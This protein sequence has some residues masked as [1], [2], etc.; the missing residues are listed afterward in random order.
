MSGRTA[1]DFDVAVV[2]GGPAGM[3]AAGQAAEA[4]S[5][6]VLLE[7]NP[8]PGKKLGITGKGRCNITND[9]GADEFLAHVVTGGRFLRSALSRFSP[10]DTMDFFQ[11]LGLPL[12]TERG[13][14]VFPQSDRAGD[15]TAA[16]RRWLDRCG[17]AV[18][19][20]RVLEIN[21]RDGAVLGLTCSDGGLTCT[22]AVVA[23]GG[24][25]YP[26]TGCTGDGYA[27][28]EACGHTVQ[29]P[30]PSLVPVEA[31]GCAALQGLGLK[32]VTLSVYSGDKRIFHEMGELLFT[33][34]GVSGPLVLS[35]S[36]VMRDCLIERCR[37]EIDL[38]P[39]LHPEQLN[40]RL[41]RDLS[42]HSNKAVGNVLAL[43]LH[44]R[45]VPAMLEAC[46]IDPALPA[47]TLTKKQRQTLL[48]GIKRYVVAPTGLRPIDEAVVTAGGVSLAEIDP[49]TMASK[50][51]AGL[52][53]AGEVMDL[54][55]QTGGYNLQ[56]AWTTGYAAGRAAGRK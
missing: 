47:H 26:G 39:G 10:G 37:L 8:F 2:G 9:C 13:R 49:K 15:V 27:M 18:R 34:F 3:M 24:L 20:T 29:T 7:R 16:L 41:L 11:S 54:D 53:F 31:P 6:V 46:G 23:T 33:H 22:R 35:A 1:V 51:C 12:K 5:R 48:A 50:R 52:Y 21:G 19:H 55:A 4:G 36:A 40:D 30:R 32:N 17:V 42:A 28:A 43:L 14:R 38:K 44:A 25:S 56:I 45:M